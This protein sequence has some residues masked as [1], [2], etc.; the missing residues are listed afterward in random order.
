MMGELIL[1]SHPL[2][3][4]PYYIEDAAQ[5]V[6]SMEELCY[7]IEKN[8]Y[9]LEQDFMDMELIGW[10]KKEAEM[11]ELAEK[12]EALIHEG[13]KLSAFVE[14]ILKETGYTPAPVIWEV[15]HTLADM[16]GKSPLV[17]GKIRADRCMQ[18]KRYVS[19]IYGYQALLQSPE[20][21]QED[22]AM[23][24]NIWH[25]LGTAYARLFLLK[26]AAH[27]FEKAYS[28]NGNQES[29]IECLYAYRCQHDG[30][31]FYQKAEAYGVGEEI[32]NQVDRRLAKVSRDET[33]TS[34]EQQLDAD[35]DTALT[36]LADN[37]AVMKIVDD[38]KNEYRK[39]L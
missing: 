11:P 3:A 12:L 26:E 23:R 13:A 15:V 31:G 10:V 24:G 14:C 38:W 16:D 20:E 29:L 25:N 4:M 8:V 37:E 28:I 5:N 21:K 2:A 19:A 7:Y 33:V 9:L 27:C 34:F 36:E 22:A 1:C 39:N 17:R 32:L 30:D 6:Y 18:T 35:M